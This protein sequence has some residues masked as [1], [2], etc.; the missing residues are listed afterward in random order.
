MKLT[1]TVSQVPNKKLWY[2][3]KIGHSN[4]PAII[5]GIHTFGTKKHALQTAAIMQCL[6]YEDYMKLRRKTR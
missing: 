5:D 4:I 2:A 3:H 1:Y 6:P